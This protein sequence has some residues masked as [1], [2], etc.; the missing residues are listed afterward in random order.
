LKHA[1]CFGW[2]DG[3]RNKFDGDFFLQKFTPRRPRSIWSQV[4]REKVEAL[5][6]EGKMREAGFAE[7]EQAK[8]D[9][10][11]DA[12]YASQKNMSVP[13]DFQMMLDQNPEAQAFFDTLN[14]TNRYAILF[15]ITTA[16]K[17][18]TRQRRMEKFL[19]MLLAKETVY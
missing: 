1:L 6:A 10:R 18:E 3:Q 7:I 5:I 8:A 12:A 19:A 9:G 16:K 2:I 15:R 4:N 17:P 14:S 11:W 13:E